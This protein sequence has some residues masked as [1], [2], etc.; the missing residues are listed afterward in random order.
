VEDLFNP[1]P[2]GVA[3]IVG[4]EKNHN[5]LAWAMIFS[6]VMQVAFTTI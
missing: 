3:T 6:A 4:G 1:D 2:H 5:P